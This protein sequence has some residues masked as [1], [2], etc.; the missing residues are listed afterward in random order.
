VHAALSEP[1]AGGRWVV[2]TARHT[3]FYPAHALEVQA[4]APEARAMACG[5]FLTPGPLPHAHMQR[6]D[7]LRL[8]MELL[9]AE[10]TGMEL[11]ETVRNMKLEVGASE[12]FSLA[13]EHVDQCNA[14]HVHNMDLKRE[15]ANA[16]L[17]FPA[18]S[19]ASL[20][21]ITHR[22]AVVETPKGY[23]FGRV[24]FAPQ[25]VPKELDFASNKP[26]NYSAGLPV[27]L[28]G[29]AVS[30]AMGM[31]AS[32]NRHS[33]GSTSSNKNESFNSREVAAPT[34]LDPCCGSGT[35]VY[36][37]WRRGS[38]SRGVDAELRMVEMAAANLMHFAN[39]FPH[40]PQP[41]IELGDAAELSLQGADVI[42]SNLP[43]GRSVSFGATRLSRRR[44]L[45]ASEASNQEDYES[46]A[47][48]SEVLVNLRDKAERHVFFT[49]RPLAAQLKACGYTGITEV[50]VCRG[51]R[52]YMSI[53]TGNEVLEPMIEFMP[54]QSYGSA[55]QVVGAGFSSMV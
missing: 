40:Q 1:R 50:P 13:Y 10:P 5:V 17:G 36:E 34:V 9:A 35:I 7:G 48:L 42:I 14:G 27:A 38:C 15:L 39:N 33:L 55:M 43:F 28:A 22:L 12:R 20:D 49:G 32:N 4:V 11:V 37:A 51:G 16:V 31:F 24:R 8:E 47:F 29:A 18:H 52:R 30:V 21:E 25:A 54:P 53:S 46:V 2:V 26:H 19:K 44:H 23:L 3:D 6:M 41:T 45:A